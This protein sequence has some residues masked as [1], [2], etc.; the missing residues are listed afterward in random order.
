MAK[1][2]SVPEEMAR[3]IQDS[4]ID[5][6]DGKKLTERDTNVF[7]TDPDGSKEMCMYPLHEAVL[8]LFLGA[9]AGCSSWIELEMFGNQNLRWLRKFYGYEN[10]IPSRDEIMYIFGRI[11][12]DQFQGFIISFLT[13]NLGCLQRCLRV[14]ASSKNFSHI[15]AADGKVS[16]QRTLHV[17]DITYGICI[18]SQTIEF[19]TDEIPAVQQWLESQKT[20]KDCLIILEAH[21]QAETWKLIRSKKGECIG[22]L[23]GSQGG[24]L[25][26]VSRC[27]GE[28]TLKKIKEEKKDYLK[29]T[30]KTH[31]QTEIREYFRVDPCKNP[32]RDGK[33][34]KIPSFVCFI[35]TIQPAN[36]SESA[37]AEARYYITTLKDVADCAEGIR[38]HWQCEAGHWFLGTEFREDDTCAMERDAYQNLSLMIKMD[39]HL[40]KALKVLPEFQKAS[41]RSIHMAVGWNRERTIKELFSLLDKKYVAEL[42]SEVRMTDTDKKKARKLMEEEQEELSEGLE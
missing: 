35:R 15:Y 1:R 39:L 8:L 20:L 42:L 24:L 21:T 14:K 28:E 12:N 29:V 17:W 22:D 13:A 11:P 30:E 7:E 23:M 4:G 41:I 37:T 25:E 32:E 26:E 19:E 27:F 6:G 34:G 40:L 36:P 31:S 5:P 3:T 18:C 2:N 16:N 38:S 33:W 9:L 10:G